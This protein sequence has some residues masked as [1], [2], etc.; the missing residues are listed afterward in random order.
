MKQLIEEYRK[1]LGKVRLGQKKLIEKGHR[2]EQDQ[3]DLRILRS[4]ENDLLWAIKWLES[5][6]QPGNQRGIENRATYQREIL[7]SQLSEKEQRQVEW[8]ESQRIRST[9]KENKWLE[10][11]LRKL[12]KSEYEAFVAVRGEG[13]SFAQTALLLH[14][15]KSTVQSYVR[16][17][18]EKLRQYRQRVDLEKRSLRSEPK[19]VIIPS[20]QAKSRHFS[21]E[22]LFV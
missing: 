5:G 21:K 10:E 16:R 20:R 6:R 15:S 7:W 3:E 17:A 1:S 11:M 4:M 14:C 2:T 13:L 8:R 12:S 9:C 19:K 22:D 18:E